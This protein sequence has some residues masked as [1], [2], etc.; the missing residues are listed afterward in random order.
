MVIR[1]KS[2]PI[3]KAGKFVKDGAVKLGAKAWGKFATTALG[4]VV[5]KEGAKFAAKTGIKAAISAAGSFAPIVGNIIGWVIGEIVTEL[6][7]KTVGLLKNIADK[8]LAEIGL[9]T[10]DFIKA[11]L[12]GAVAGVA[13]GSVGV[14]IIVGGTALIG[15]GAIAAVITLVVAAILLPI[16]IIVLG[17]PIALALFLYIINSGSYIVPPSTYTLSSGPGGPVF[18]PPTAPGAGFDCE[19]SGNPVSAPGATVRLLPSTVE[20]RPQQKC[21]TPTTIV[22]HWSGGAVVNGVDRTYETL[23][24]RNLA[25]HYAT[26]PATTLEMLQ[27]W[28]NK[29]EFS[30]CQGYYNGIGI[31]IEMSGNCFSAMPAYGCSVANVTPPPEAEIQ[32]TINLACWLRQQYNIERVVGHFEIP[33]AD[34]PDP[35]QEFLYN[36][37]IPRMNNQCPYTPPEPNPNPGPGPGPQPI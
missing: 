22:I 9:S 13:F 15:A 31:G 30:W 8:I 12:F 17:I 33:Y 10:D 29:V 24:Q 16:L 11:G 18:L 2:T 27:M 6:L 7:D 5:V 20:P 23:V 32:R 35:G 37:F 25:C 26:D 21:I 28:E 4:K 3:Y 34:K 36:T 1:G 14:G 19:N